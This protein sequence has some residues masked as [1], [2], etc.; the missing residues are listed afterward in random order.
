[1]RVKDLLER[2]GVKA[3]AVDLAMSA[4]DGYT[5]SIPIDKALNGDVIAVYEMNG[6]A[7]AR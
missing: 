2:A 1:M 5:E 6:V 4:R 7:A 3:G